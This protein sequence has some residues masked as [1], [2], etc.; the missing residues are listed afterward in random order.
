MLGMFALIF[1]SGWGSL[2]SVA[3]RATGVKDTGTLLPG[4]GADGQD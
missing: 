4:H 1:V 2:V 3:K